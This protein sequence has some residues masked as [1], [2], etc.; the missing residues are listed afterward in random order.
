MLRAV[1]WTFFKVIVS[2]FGLGIVIGMLYAPFDDSPAWFAMLAGWFVTLAVWG[3][4]FLARWWGEGY[5]RR[6][7]GEEASNQVDPMQSL[8]VRAGVTG[9]IVVL[10]SFMMP[11]YYGYSQLPPSALTGWFISA[12]ILSGLDLLDA[13][14][15]RYARRRLGDGEAAFEP[16]KHKPKRGD[17]QSKYDLLMQ[18]MDEDERAA[19]KEALQR[20]VAGN[21][22][23]SED[24]E[25][26]EEDAARLGLFDDEGRMHDQT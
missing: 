11:P 16:P 22:R 6:L 13:Y 8:L 4:P 10:F 14:G 7:G 24:G 21:H 17:N 18:L 1:L 2:L 15:Q 25:L 23:F 9:A 20:R 26:S 12:V 3:I 5:V 19:F